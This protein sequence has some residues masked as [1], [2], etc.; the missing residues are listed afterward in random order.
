MQ[1][2]PEDRVAL[3]RRYYQPMRTTTALPSK[4]PSPGL[5]LHQSRR[6][7]IDQATYFQ[8]C[9]A[10]HERIESFTLLDV[11][12]DA[13]GALVR[14]RAAEFS[15]PGFANDEHFEFTGDRISH[16]DVYFGRE[17]T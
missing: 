3:I 1:S 7:P 11:C 10:P 17:L 8:R 9:W 16:V 14:Y 12:A 15:G 2:G 4:N 6:R 13:Q 5:H